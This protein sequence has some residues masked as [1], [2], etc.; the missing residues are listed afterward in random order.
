[1]FHMEHKSRDDSGF[2][3]VYP[4]DTKA[5]SND[6]EF[7]GYASI[8]GNVDQGFDIVKAG[9]F[10][11]SLRSKPMNKV[12]MLL[13]H[14]PR[15]LIGAWQGISSDT[16]GLFVRGKLLLKTIAGQETYERMKA[17]ILDG[18]SIGFRTLDHEY[19]SENAVRTV[20]RADLWEV[21]LVT[22][23]MNEQALVSSVKSENITTIRKFEEFLRDEGH[24]SHARAK[25]IACSGFKSSEPRDED[26]ALSDLLSAIRGVREDLT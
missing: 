13:Q 14:E 22:F 3:G 24:F 10:D 26:D 4:I 15:D 25:A 8:Y 23:P 17:G 16:K 11:E 5:T 6:G 9:S 2:G 19:D 1:M 21:S 7:E 20:T 12:K 18:L